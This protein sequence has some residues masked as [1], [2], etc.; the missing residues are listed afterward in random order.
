MDIVEITMNDII[1]AVL[2]VETMDAPLH[3]TFL[4]NLLLGLWASTGNTTRQVPRSSWP[5][6]LKS[7]HHSSGSAI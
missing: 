5:G 6:T 3:F 4:E 7:A 1:V 2:T